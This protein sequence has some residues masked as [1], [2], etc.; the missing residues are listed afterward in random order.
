MGP[1]TKELVEVLD[2]LIIILDEDEIENWAS[3]MSRAREL[4]VASDFSG[5]ERVLN[6]YGGM[7]SFNDI[8]LKKIT[9]KNCNFSKLHN[10]A[11]ELSKEISR[12]Q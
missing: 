9:K 6:A 3:Y 8:S 4:I 5:V 7:G 1:K 12:A 2:Q 10:R 11:W